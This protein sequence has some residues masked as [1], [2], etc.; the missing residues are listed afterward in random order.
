MTDMMKLYKRITKSMLVKAYKHYL[1]ENGRLRK[2]N[3]GFGTTHGNGLERPKVGG[4]TMSW[5][6]FERQPKDIII[7]CL[8]TQGC[9]KEYL[10][11]LEKDGF[12][13]RSSY[14]SN[15]LPLA[16]ELLEFTKQNTAN[17]IP[18][19]TDG[20]KKL[21]RYGM[22]CKNRNALQSAHDARVKKKKVKFNL[23]LLGLD[24]N[25]E[26]DLVKKKKM[27][28]KYRKWEQKKQTKLQSDFDYYV[29]SNAYDIET[30]KYKKTYLTTQE[31]KDVRR[32]EESEWK[33]MN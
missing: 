15:M 13:S 10:A 4:E 32:K 16:K 25:K 24:L 17:G 31:W 8:Y 1:E 3:D 27:F 14:E 23:K 18:L 30:D 20:P 9:D 28:R 19:T 22:V 11:K 5:N 12:F 6:E 2:R 33:T 7:V 21:M 29:V 26:E